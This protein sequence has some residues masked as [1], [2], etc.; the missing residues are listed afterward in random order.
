MTSKQSNHHSIGPF[1]DRVAESLDGNRNADVEKRHAKGFRTARENLEHLIDQ[2]SFVEYGQFAVAAQRS[3]R[4]LDE[5]KSKTAGDGVI[6]GLAKI[7]TQQFGAKKSQAVVIVN[8]YMSL[9]GTQGFF[10]HA[11][12]DRML[13]VATERSLPVV[14]IRETQISFIFS[15]RLNFC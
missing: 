15:N 11:K 13:Q 6:T 2:G 10:H 5:L 7:N 12:I 1:M 8:D 4:S 14:M 9:A 3:R